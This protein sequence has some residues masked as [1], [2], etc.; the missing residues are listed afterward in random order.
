ML[1]EEKPFFFFFFKENAKLPPASQEDQQG[2]SLAQNAIK[3]SLK[4]KPVLECATS[5]ER[6][7][8]MCEW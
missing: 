7:S 8:V 3:T 4:L 6:G 2:N 1:A 5:Q